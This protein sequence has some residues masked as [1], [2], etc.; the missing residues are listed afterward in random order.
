MFFDEISKYDYWR[1][2]RLILFLKQSQASVNNVFS[3][4]KEN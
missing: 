1:F 4:E 3:L 2:N